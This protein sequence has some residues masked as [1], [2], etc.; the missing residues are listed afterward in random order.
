[1]QLKEIKMKKILPHT[2]LKEKKEEEKKYPQKQ[3]S[4]LIQA[5]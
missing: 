5:F 1:M 2:I 4:S 3:R